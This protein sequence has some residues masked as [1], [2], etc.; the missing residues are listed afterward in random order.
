ME[1][2]METSVLERDH[3]REPERDDFVLAHGDEHERGAESLCVG[4]AR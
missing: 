2:E 1:F 4:E 3:Y